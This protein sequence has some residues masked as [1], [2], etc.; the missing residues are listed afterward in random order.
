MACP[1]LSQVQHPTMVDPVHANLEDIWAAFAQR[2]AQLSSARHHQRYSYQKIHV[3]ARVESSA[4]KSAKT[5]KL[6]PKKL[7]SSTF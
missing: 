3:S 6:Q 5:S 2:S 1:A 7:Y 4:L